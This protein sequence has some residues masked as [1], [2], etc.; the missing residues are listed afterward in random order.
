M[1]QGS[2]M[3]ARASAPPSRAAFFGQSSN[4]RPRADWDLVKDGVMEF[5]VQ[6]KLGQHPQLKE[7][8]LATK[9][10]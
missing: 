7:E 2:S 10:W 4:M 1:G 9:D 8:L 3:A 5:A 6:L